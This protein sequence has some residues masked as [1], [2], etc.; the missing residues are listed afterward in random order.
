MT[1]TL[2]VYAC[3][4]GD[5]ANQIATYFEASLSH[6][7][8]NTAHRYPP[9]CTLTG[10]FHD[11]DGSIPMYVRALEQALAECGDMPLDV[12]IDQCV[13][14]GAW[15]GLTLTAPGWIALTR[16][17]AALAA[18]SPT[19]TDSIRVKTDL[20]LSLAYGSDEH[21]QPGLARLALEGIDPG[22][23]VRWRLRFFSQLSD[24]TW[25]VLGDWPLTTHAP[26]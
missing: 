1:R 10:F 25:H 22:A 9:H 24:H 26:S 7:G 5:L 13:T 14:E 16:R 23:D 19:R 18:D 3:P 8:P 2:I 11:D 4:E 21:N 12:R 15:H 20:H 17:F 6:F